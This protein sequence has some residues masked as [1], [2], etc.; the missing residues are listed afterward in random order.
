MIADR[1]ALDSERAVRQFAVGIEHDAQLFGRI[2]RAFN[3]QPR[4]RV[5]GAVNAR[6]IGTED[7]AA[8]NDRLVFAVADDGNVVPGMYPP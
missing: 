6:L 2:A 5:N 3:G 7:D 4:Y 1:N 8:F